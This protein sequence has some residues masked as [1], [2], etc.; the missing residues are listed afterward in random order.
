[1]FFPAFSEGV[2]SRLPKE[3]IFTVEY[4]TSQILVNAE[5]S[6]LEE[7]ISRGNFI[8]ALLQELEFFGQWRKADF[9]D[10]REYLVHQQS[11]LQDI[12]KIILKERDNPALRRHWLSPHPL[13]TT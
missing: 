11:S 6:F 1:M 12:T 13:Q 7:A 2:V 3:T 10:V 5:P 9:P 4:F 8:E